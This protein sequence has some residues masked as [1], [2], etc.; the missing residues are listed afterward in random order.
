MEVAEPSV[1]TLN[2]LSAAQ[3]ANDLMMMFT[4]LFRES[5]HL[6][7]HLNF[8]R[9]RMLNVVQPRAVES[10]LDCATHSKS[11]RAWRPGPAAL[12]HAPCRYRLSSS[13]PMTRSTVTRKGIQPGSKAAVDSSE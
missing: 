5:V 6:S 7:H 9:E 13:G 10:C 3:A 4:G 8:A 12:S 2:V 1:I 11:R